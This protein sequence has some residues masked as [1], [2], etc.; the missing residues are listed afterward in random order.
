MKIV[1]YY[2]NH[3]K[4][5]LVLDQLEEEINQDDF[6]F[7]TS[8]HHSK[9]EIM[10][11]ES[12]ILPVRIIEG[13]VN[14]KEQYGNEALK[15]YTTTEALS[16]YL[17]ELQIPYQQLQTS[18]QIS[19][20]QDSNNS[21]N[22]SEEELRDLLRGIYQIYGHDFRN[23]QLQSLRRTFSQI[24]AKESMLDFKMFKEKIFQDHQFFL[25][26]FLNL[27]INVTSFFRYPDLFRV[28][29]DEVFPYLNSFP[30]LRIWSVGAASGEEAYSLAIL[31][32][33][34]NMLEK[35]IIYAT[36]FNSFVLQ[37]AQN[38]LYGLHSLKLAVENHRKAGGSKQLENY[39]DI[40]RY[41]AKMKPF[42]KRKVVFFQHNL[43]CDTAFN[44]FH[45]VICNNVLIYFNPELQENVISLFKQSLHR[46]GFLV[47]GRS[48]NL[49]RNNKDFIKFK[50]G[51][52]IYK[53][54]THC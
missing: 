18:K 28:L 41:Y 12:W 1:T 30:L 49:Y 13:L 48:E 7:E 6:L 37:K 21:I 3:T 10:F 2:K 45:L 47:L 16:Q 51:F 50:A 53:L 34:L 38:A 19:P 25:R 36:D 9:L 14:L 54:S 52:N 11:I 43:T 15:I 23:Y 4:H 44:E 32:D 26:L 31:L 22:F 5:I 29:R 24:I 33:E 39:F 8:G 46:N 40:N 35:S 20:E 42:I 17:F 27:S